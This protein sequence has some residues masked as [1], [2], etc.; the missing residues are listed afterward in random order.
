[1][2][3]SAQAWLEKLALLTFVVLL[4]IGWAAVYGLYRAGG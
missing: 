4:A 3:K 1:M 2:S